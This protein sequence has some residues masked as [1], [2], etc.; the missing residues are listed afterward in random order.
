MRKCAGHVHEL[1]V[2]RECGV[3][4][5][6]YYSKDGIRVDL[7]TLHNTSTKQSFRSREDRE[8]AL[9]ANANPCNTQSNR[10]NLNKRH[11]V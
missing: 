6:K 1:I 4:S 8:Q 2:K 10:Q 11:C 3:C 9:C 5:S 7:P